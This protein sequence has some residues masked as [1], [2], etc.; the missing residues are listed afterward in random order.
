VTSGA[1]GRLGTLPALLW[2]AA[3]LVGTVLRT[4]GTGGQ[5]LHGDEAIAVPSIERGYGTILTTFDGRGTHTGF[6]L[7]Q[8]I[9]Y[10]LLGAD[11]FSY[12]LPS[13]LAGVLTLWLLLPLGR[14]FVGTGPAWLAT[15][16][17]AVHPLHVYYSR[18]GRPYALACLLLLLLLWAAL[19]ALRGRRR[20]W[21]AVAL[22]A[23]VLPWVH[24][25][26]VGPAALLGLVLLVATL[27]E[28]ENVGR[29]LAALL[30]ALLLCVLL[31]LPA[32]GDLVD[33]LD[34]LTTR[35]GRFRPGWSTTLRLLGGSALGGACL[36][37]G[38]VLSSLRLAFRSLFA[39]LL[40]LAVLSAPPIVLLLAQPKGSH[41]AM[42][43]YLMI[44]LAP[45]LLAAAHGLRALARVSYPRLGSVAGFLCAGVLL[46]RGP[47]DATWL[48]GAFTNSHELLVRN[49]RID[50]PLPETPALY[51]E[52]ARSPAELTLVEFPFVAAAWMVLRNYELQ[53]G[54]RVLVGTERSRSR[55][56][57]SPPY[58]HLTDLAALRGRAD[59]LIVHL[60]LRAE[61]LRFLAF[62]G[63]SPH[64]Q[65]APVWRGSEERLVERF[66]EPDYRDEHVW[67]WRIE[68][69]AR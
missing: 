49:P 69:G 11:V 17:L 39:G 48:G 58:V 9:A 45:M 22:L 18:A 1:T 40:L 4:A 66:G 27:R 24:L 42:A 63:R 62:A 64:P 46:A 67:A 41:F 55:L 19:E 47:I 29:C 68:G 43:R 61:F 25:T 21:I 59:W 38:A 33:Y 57:G 16:L 50:R 7:A 36:L 28:R 23:G 3:C 2:I 37:V 35:G 26:A 20:A 13:I 32:R 34:K 54:Q 8:R 12:R 14:R 5:V 52:L 44:A 15:V 60:D 53:H 10:D 6:S 31:Y 51:R 65:R 56:L 30:A